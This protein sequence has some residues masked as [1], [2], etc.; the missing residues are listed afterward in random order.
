MTTSPYILHLDNFLF[1]IRLN[2]HVVSKIC[3]FE[4][5]LSSCSLR[6]QSFQISPQNSIP[7]KQNQSCK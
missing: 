7:L 4:S 3:Q 5:T 6:K 1:H 2:E